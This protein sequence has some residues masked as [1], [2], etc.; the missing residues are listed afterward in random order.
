M[1]ELSDIFRLYG[2]EYRAKF[3]D[4]MLKS[5]LMAMQDIEECRTEA[6]GG[7]VFL[8]QDCQK[9][10]F[11]YHSCKNRHCPKCQN[12]ETTE[13]LEK[14]SD[15]LLPVPYFFITV[16]LPSELREL[17]RSNQKV[18]YNIFFRS[19]ASALKELALDPKFIGGQIGMVGVLQTWRSD[20]WYHPHIHY[21][22]PGGGLSPD[23]K[24]WLS[25]RYQDFLVPVKALSKIFRGKFRDEI[26]KTELYQKIPKK[27]WKLKWVTH[28]EPA[29]SGKEVV[30]YLAPYVYRIAIS[31]TRIEKLENRMVTFRFKDNQT[32]EWKRETLEVLEFI[33][34]FLQHV[35][36]K[37][38][39]KIRYY[40]FLC[41]SKRKTLKTIKKLLGVINTEHVSK[42]QES[43]NNEKPL[44]CPHCGGHLILI[45]KIYRKKRAP[46]WKQNMKTK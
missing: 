17:T 44:S 14:Q 34:R 7:H 13:W 23:G 16:T 42:N 35:L 12:K 37:S 19:S 22:V 3:K 18:I 26:K 1:I 10:I 38:F 30:K 31:N 27:V 41:S 46:P 45:E 39:V 32:N 20:M 4:R 24:N 11:S 28:V 2:D 43:K 8:C 33:R 36:P 25:S 5:H 21:I 40:G 15:N 9:Q 29:G 6:F